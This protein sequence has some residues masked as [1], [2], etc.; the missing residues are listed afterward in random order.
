MQQAEQ[1]GRLPDQMPKDF[2]VRFAM[3]PFRLPF[4]GLL[5][6]HLAVICGLAAHRLSGRALIRRSGAQSE[7]DWLM[8]LI[9]L[10]ARA[11]LPLSRV[12]SGTAT[13]AAHQAASRTP[14]L[15]CLLE[16][17]CNLQR[18]S[19]QLRQQLVR[20]SC[21]F[22]GCC[23]LCR[24]RHCCPPWE[25]PTA[26][27]QTCCSVGTGCSGSVS[28]MAAAT[29]WRHH[30]TAPQYQMHTIQCGVA[31]AESNYTARRCCPAGAHR[32]GRRPL[33]WRHHRGDGRADVLW[34][35]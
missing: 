27:R 34:P 24:C 16:E 1:R 35:R 4:P 29:P 3:T 23:S 10:D 7:P 20:A 19:Q 18:H 8:D 21:V 28:T 11:R 15:Y 14:R 32:L 12:A 30:G 5:Y 26:S 31:H 6:V 9:V 2:L 33:P 17:R 13:A 22:D 25:A